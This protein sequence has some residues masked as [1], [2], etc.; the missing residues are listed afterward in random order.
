MLTILLRVQWTQI[1]SMW[2]FYVRNR[3]SG[4]GYIPSIWVLGPLGFKDSGSKIYTWYGAWNLSPEMGSIW[5]PWA[6]TM[7]GSEP[8]DDCQMCIH[9]YIY[10]YTHHHTG[11][12]S[13][14]GLQEIY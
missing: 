6:E 3:N 11:V 10:I 13:I 12:D 14:W 2:G 7:G 4:F 5:F 1:W 9:I 8:V